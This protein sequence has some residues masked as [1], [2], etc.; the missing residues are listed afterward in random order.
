MHEIGGGGTAGVETYGVAVS[1]ERGT[2]VPLLR[3]HSM[4]YACFVPPEFLGCNVTTLAP[5]TALKLIASFT[6]TFDDRVV[7]HRVAGSRP[8]TAPSGLL[9]FR[10]ARPS[11]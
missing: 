3:C 2:P 1:Y 11:G 8:G 9:D 6:L 7:L 10:Y 5:H 4:E